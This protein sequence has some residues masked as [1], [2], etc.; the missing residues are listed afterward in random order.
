MM[1]GT[2][3]AIK[4]LSRTARFNGTSVRLQ[5]ALSSPIK[6]EPLDGMSG[7]LDEPQRYFVS[8]TVSKIAV[9]SF[10]QRSNTGFKA[11]AG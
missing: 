6:L 7:S 2:S 8:R 1:A 4:S 5:L 10:S 9:K 11:G 3:L